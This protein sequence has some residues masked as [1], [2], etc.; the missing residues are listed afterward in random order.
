MA[1]KTKESSV[2][3]VT[4]WDSSTGD[5]LLTLRTEFGTGNDARMVL[6]ATPRYAQ[7]VS[8]KYARFGADAILGSSKLPTHVP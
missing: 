4:I 5:E 7:I 6:N 2:R 8:G 3:L 1:A